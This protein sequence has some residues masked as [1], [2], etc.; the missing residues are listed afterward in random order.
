[1]IDLSWGSKYNFL[2]MIMT[3]IKIFINVNVMY[4]FVICNCFITTGPLLESTQIEAPDDQETLPYQQQ[5]DN[6]DQPMIPYS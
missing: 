6:D 5:Q 2:L 1:M 4:V 3:M